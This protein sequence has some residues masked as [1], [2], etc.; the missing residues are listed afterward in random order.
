MAGSTRV[1]QRRTGAAHSANL[2]RPGHGFAV[3]LDRSIEELVE[4]ADFV[5]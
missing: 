1:R 3:R 2:R 4:V 5:T